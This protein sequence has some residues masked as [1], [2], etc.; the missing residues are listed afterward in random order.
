MLTRPFDQILLASAVLALFSGGANAV[1]PTLQ[2]TA[3]P[4]AS[5]PITSGSFSFGGVTVD[6][7]PIVGSIGEPE[8]Q[9]NGLV[10]L[11]GLFN[12][13]DVQS[14]EYNL[15]GSGGA[16]SFTAS[17]SGTLEP[18]TSLDWSVYYDPANE[19]FGESDTFGVARLRQSVQSR[20][21]DSSCRPWP[22]PDRS[23]ALSR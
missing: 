6:G 1:T 13:V 5:V 21:W 12:P 19:P 8:L 20:E 3:G 23:R 15:G 18:L 9:V 7:V 2:F 11:G 10:T 14:T 17:I 16:A 4:V 22:L